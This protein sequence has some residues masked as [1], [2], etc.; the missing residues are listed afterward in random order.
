MGNPTMDSAMRLTVCGMSMGEI[1]R[2]ALHS[3]LHRSTSDRY[4]HVLFTDKQLVT[5]SVVDLV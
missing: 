3:W 4:S 1:Q 2:L 5:D